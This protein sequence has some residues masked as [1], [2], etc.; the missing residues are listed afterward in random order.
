M[1]PQLNYTG[2]VNKSLHKLNN[3][4]REFD[5]TITAINEKFHSLQQNLEE[6][7]HELLSGLIAEVDINKVLYDVISNFKLNV[8]L[9]TEENKEFLQSKLIQVF[10]KTL[11]S[12]SNLGF[13]E[14]EIWD[15][16]QEGALRY[17]QCIP[18]GYSDKDKDI[19]KYGDLIIWKELLGK[20]I[21]KTDLSYL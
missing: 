8:A 6:Q 11:C 7:G 9:S 14:E 21:K 1:V 19:N 15:I 18:P 4:D 5:K 17:E 10:H 3:F 13:T 20:L 12:K 2:E 16:E